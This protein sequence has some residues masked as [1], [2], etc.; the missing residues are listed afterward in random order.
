[1]PSTMSAPVEAS[2]ITSGMPSSR[3]V[4][5]AVSTTD[6]V[7]DDNGTPRKPDSVRPP[8]STQT[9]R[10]PSIGVTSAVTSS[11]TRRWSPSDAVEHPGD[12]TRG[13]RPS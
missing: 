1:M 13:V 2:T 4:R 9:T 6:E 7:A 12:P 11:S 5:A 8:S 3:A 10:R